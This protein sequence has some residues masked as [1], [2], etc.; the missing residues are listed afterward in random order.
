MMDGIYHNFSINKST[1]MSIKLPELERY[2]NVSF[3]QMTEDWNID[4]I[5]F[6]NHSGRRCKPID[7]GTDAQ[8]KQLYELWVHEDYYFDIFCPDL[9]TNDIKFYSQEGENFV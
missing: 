2:V 9:T 8:S 7:F 4:K 6:N 3:H 1:N 5:T